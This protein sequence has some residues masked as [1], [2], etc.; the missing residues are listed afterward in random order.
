MPQRHLAILLSGL[1]LTSLAG[2]ASLVPHDDTSVAPAEQSQQ[3]LERAT[4]CCSTLAALPYQSL[5]VG[6]SQS[7]TLDTQAPMHRFADGASYFQAFELPRTRE[8][9]TFKL[10]STIANDQ[11]FAPTVLVLDEDFQPTQRVASD[12]FD[13]LSPNG[14]AGARLGA[15][16]DITPGPDAAYLVVYSNDAARQGTTQYESA[17]KVYARVRGL[18][19]PPGPDPI[20]EHTATGNVTLESEARKTS[21]G[22]LT[23]ILGTRSHADSVTA[24]TGTDA[25]RSEHAAPSSGDS[26]NASAPDFDY[27]RMIDAALKADDIELAMQLAER[28]EREG[29]SGTRA[30]LAERLRSVSP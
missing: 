8:P 9:L 24:D 15:T 12:K 25:S 3:A 11:V 21:G 2:C 13:Y 16:F 18:A 23:P 26:N 22:L 1:A 28:A 6:E 10:T 29:N 20:A 4:D 14:F 7:L 19:L 17:E 30:W 5:A 27:R